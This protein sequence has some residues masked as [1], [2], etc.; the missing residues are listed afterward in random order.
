MP[1]PP[2]SHTIDARVSELLH[3]FSQAWTTGNADAFA[4]L[5]TEDAVFWPPAGEALQGRDPIRTWIAQLGETK[6][7]ALQ[8]LRADVFGEIV[9]VVGNFAHDL[10]LPTGL[11]AFRGGLTS[12][13]RDAGGILLVHRLVSFQGRTFS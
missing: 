10:D 2:D 12:I 6:H 7:L 1:V 9:F 5:W 3:N 13:L 8:I 11:I 4:A